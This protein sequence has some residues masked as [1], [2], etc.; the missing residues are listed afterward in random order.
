MNRQEGH[1]CLGAEN[2]HLAGPRTNVI[3]LRAQA[4]CFLGRTG[5]QP[6]TSSLSLPACHFQP[7]TDIEMT[8]KD[9]GPTG[10]FRARDQ[11]LG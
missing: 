1:V 7:V 8:G 9:A 11:G 6:V 5:F 4:L 10:I 3:E 2:C